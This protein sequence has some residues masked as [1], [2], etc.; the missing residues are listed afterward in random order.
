MQVIPTLSERGLDV[1]ALD[2]VG[3]GMSDKPLVAEEISFELHMRTLISLFERYDLSET[4]ILAHDWG[5][6][7]L[8]PGHCFANPALG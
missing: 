6:W 8:Y 7:V 1:Y 3:F 5:G 2:W 4:H